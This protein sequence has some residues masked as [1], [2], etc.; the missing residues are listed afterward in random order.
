MMNSIKQAVQ[1]MKYK[2]KIA[3]AMRGMRRG[4]GAAYT[5]QYQ[6]YM[7]YQDKLMSLAKEEE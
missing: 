1:V 3:Q 2:R 7:H 4:R 5:Y 6:R